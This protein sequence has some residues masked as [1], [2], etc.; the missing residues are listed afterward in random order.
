MFARHRKRQALC[1]AGGGVTGIYFEMG[2]LKCLDDCL[3]GDALGAFDMYFG[4]S[5][6]AVVTGLMAA[7]YSM[8]EFMAAVAGVDGGRLP[9]I[10]MRVFRLSHI[11]YPDVARRLGAALR[12]GWSTVWNTLRDGSLPTLEDLF[13]Q[14]AD[15]IGAPFRADGFEQLLRTA[16]TAPGATNDFRRLPRKLYIG[17][18]DQDERRHQLFGVDGRDTVEISVAIQASMSLNPAF[19]ST[20][21]QGRYYEDGAVTRTSNF[22]EAIRRGADLIFTIDPMVPYVSLEPGFAARRGMLY[23]VDQNLRTI[24]YTRF[25]NTRNWILR[26]HPDVSSYTFVP[27][28]R[29]RRLLSISPFDH[30]PYLEIWRAAYLSTLLRVQNLAHRMRGDL[31][32][33]GITLD[34]GRAEAVAERLSATK[35]PTLADFFPDGRIEIKQPPLCLETPEAWTAATHQESLAEATCSAAG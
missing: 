4:I 5:A 13:F 15:V 30:R 32:F 9:R 8:D 17:A 7:G 2:S 23:N 14:Y 29:V 34:T 28:N 35:H 21:I 26:R 18:T 1:A 11:N 24:S 33:H 10:D 25:E 22:A 6:G 19:A 12:S 27:A 3:L 16:L 31:A 20:Q